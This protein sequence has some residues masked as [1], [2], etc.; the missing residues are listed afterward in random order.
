MVR[1]ELDCKACLP[2]VHRIDHNE[3]LDNFSFS[4]LFQ[5]VMSSSSFLINYAIILYKTEEGKG[6]VF[7][8]QM[9]LSPLD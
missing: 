8:S 3:L 1:L 7:K 5:T 4:V 6:P 2:V 9:E